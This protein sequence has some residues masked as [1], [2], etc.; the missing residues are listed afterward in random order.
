MNFDKLKSVY[1]IGIGG[2]G[3]SAIARYFHAHGKKVSGYDKTPTQLTDELIQEGIEVRFV[4]DA[5]EIRNRNLETGSCLVV[6]TPAVPKDHLELNYFLQN[7][8]TVMKRSQVLGLITANHFT[9]AVAG[10]HGKTTTSSMIAHILKSSGVN[11]TAFL[12]GISKN[13]NSNLILPEDAS[14]KSVV[15]VEADEYD[16]SFL[17]LH[18]DIAVITSMDADHLDIYGDQNYMEDSYRMFAKQIKNNGVLISRSGLPVGNID[19]VQKQ[20]SLSEKVD[21]SASDIQIKNHQYYF[22]WHNHVS[23]IENLATLM[24][25]RHNVE[26]VIAAIAVAREIKISHE[27]IAEAVHSYSGVRRRFDYQVKTDELVYIDDYAH[28]P[29]ELRACISSVRELYP[30]RTITG[31]FQPHLFTRT[32][33]FA[34]GFAKSL[35]LLDE[36]ILLDIYPAR[37]LP[38]EGVTS[39]L[40][41][42]KV[43]IP[44]KA[45]CRKE[46]VMVELKARKVEVLLTLGAGDID[47]LVE[48]IRNYL[49]TTTQKP[50]DKR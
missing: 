3:M 35:S 9:I 21:F 38:I 46:G 18:P 10:T 2:I 15:V 7:G 40:I 8:F 24:P 16:R 45:L 32:R 1:F 43:S 14:K 13:Y 36:L 47:Q 28:H 5:T 22:N 17:T 30:G 20:Y 11:C 27:K 41:L 6:Y 42:N 33:D 29:E 49:N 48:P 39:E 26:N 19:A 44:N 23:S 12:G 50:T 34:D 37:E 4:D 25:G 31:I